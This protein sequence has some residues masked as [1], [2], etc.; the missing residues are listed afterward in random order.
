MEKEYVSGQVSLDYVMANILNRM[1]ADE[2]DYVHLKQLMIDGYQDL[3]MFHLNIV[4][5][6]NCDILD[7]NVVPFPNDYL[8]YSKIATIV[9][10]K[11]YTLTRDDSIPLPRQ[12]ECGVESNEVNNTISEPVMYGDTMKPYPMTRANSLAFFDDTA[13]KNIGYYRLDEERRLIILKGYF[14]EGRIILE[15]AVVAVD[16]NGET[17][18]PR[19]VVPALRAYVMWAT[20]EY[21]PRVTIND[22]KMKKAAYDAEVH[23]VR[24]IS[25]QM[26]M[27]EWMDI[28]NAT[29]KQ[30]VKR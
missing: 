9:G 20:C 21:D 1:K 16:V 24:M 19:Y 14:P 17:M 26:T 18:V 2:R 28:A 4:K 11:I 29:K 7:G 30:T 12:Y 23:K 25:N 6:K 10:R 3:C 5:V 27:D 8:Y 15:Y 22:K 13:A